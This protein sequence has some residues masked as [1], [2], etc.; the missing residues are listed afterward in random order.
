M[1]TPL[2]RQASTGAWIV[3]FLGIHFS[4]YLNTFHK[5]SFICAQVF[6]ANVD[7]ETS[8][9]G[10]EVSKQQDLYTG[11]HFGLLPSLPCPHLT[12]LVLAPLP[13]KINRRSNL[14]GTGL[15]GPIFLAAAN[16]RHKIP[17]LR[18]RG[19]G[20]E[21]AQLFP[22]GPTQE[23]TRSFR[24]TLRVKNP[25]PSSIATLISLL[26]LLNLLVDWVPPTLGFS[27]HMEQVSC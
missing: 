2:P 1:Q 11:V 24:I 10:A 14:P 6:G 13:G 20:L 16:P 17:Q 7:R 21:L 18:C 3:G 23:K 22:L 12:H 5:A 27:V 4:T 26:F 19:P 15:I 8:C 9:Q 25:P